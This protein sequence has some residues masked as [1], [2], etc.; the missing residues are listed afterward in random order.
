MYLKIVN[1]QIHLNIG[2]VSTL[3]LDGIIKITS[4]NF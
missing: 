4:K 2:I 3:S 1:S